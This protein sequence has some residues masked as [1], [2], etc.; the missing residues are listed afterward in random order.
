MYNMNL[1]VSLCLS[2]CIF[3]TG[4]V[5]QMSLNVFSQKVEHFICFMHDIWIR[6]SNFRPS[7]HI[8]K[9]LKCGCTNLIKNFYSGLKYEWPFSAGPVDKHLCECWK[10][11]SFFFSHCVCM[12]CGGH[13][14]T[15]SQLKIKYLFF[16]F[17]LQLNCVSVWVCSCLVVIFLWGSLANVA[18]LVVSV[19][20][21]PIFC[22][23]I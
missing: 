16:Y 12:C 2:P 14:K 20:Y 13:L 9:L 15:S 17:V 11:E 23:C 7:V 1:Y 4:D 19:K 10:D 5:C 8:S 22:F 6:Y 18:R 21:V 3:P